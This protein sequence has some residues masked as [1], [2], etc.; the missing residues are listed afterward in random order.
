MLCNLIAFQKHEAPE[1]YST[2]QSSYP[3]LKSSPHGE[4]TTSK[5]SPFPLLAALTFRSECP[6]LGDVHF[7]AAFAV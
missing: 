5:G 3:F 6:D 1:R 7:P 2:Q 4:L